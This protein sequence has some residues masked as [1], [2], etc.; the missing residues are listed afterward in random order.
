M[1]DA[2]GSCFNEKKRAVSA[3][4]LTHP[5]GG[6]VGTSTASVT[7]CDGDRISA[8]KRVGNE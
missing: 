8:G 5:Q 2:P 4:G 6:G 3:A 1:L 7:K